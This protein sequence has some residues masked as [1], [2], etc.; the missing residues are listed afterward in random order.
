MAPSA[1]GTRRVVALVAYHSAAQ[2]EAE[3]RGLADAL[4]R[5]PAPD[6][7]QMDILTLI[8]MS[9]GTT[10]ERVAVN[11]RLAEILERYPPDRPSE[12][13]APRKPVRRG[14]LVIPFAGHGSCSL[15]RS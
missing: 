9:T 5:F 10:G 1:S 7:D 6:Q 14:G 12:L 4:A 15:S 3:A 8:D 11:E 13:P 2:Y